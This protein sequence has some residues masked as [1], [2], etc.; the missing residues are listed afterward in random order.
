MVYDYTA[1]CKEGDDETITQHGA[2]ET[3]FIQDQNVIA[4]A[5]AGARS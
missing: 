2:D 3:I 4:Q 5:T 1:F